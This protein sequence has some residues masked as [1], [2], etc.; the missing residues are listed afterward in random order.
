M[1]RLWWCGLL[2]LTGACERVVGVTLDE[3]PKRLV[4]EARL[5]RV[6]ENINGRQRIRL[7]TTDAYFS[8]AIAPPARGAVVT[9]S[10][11]S[12]TTVRFSESASEAGVYETNALTVQ[13]GAT[14]SLQIEFGGDR[15]I[16][17]ETALS[18]AKID[19]LYFTNG[20]GVVGSAPGLRATIDVV[21]PRGIKNF[22]LWDQ[23][24]DGRRLVFADTSFPSRA[25][26]S[27]ELLDGRRIRAYQPY[28]GVVVKSGQQVLVR[29]IALSE[30]MYR[31]YLALSEQ[32]G[33]DG[34][35]FGVP[36]AS[37]RGNV[38]NI[39]NPSRRPLGY[40]MAAEVAEAARRV[41]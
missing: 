38:E 41:P 33:N 24:V 23:F 30:S 31:Y 5:E 15:Y 12:G 22:Y 39:T 40:F 10:D 26:A 3:G 35:P 7:T 17:S 6:K 19:S 16:A 20:S 14:Y 8:G 18:V 9:V 11:G 4:V 21:D 37:V 29:Q 2:L 32:A 28:E 34:S 25:A 1:R 27:D 36:A 13:L